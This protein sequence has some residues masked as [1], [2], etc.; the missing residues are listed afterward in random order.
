MDVSDMDRIYGS[1]AN[2]NGELDREWYE[3]NIVSVLLPYPMRR[4]GNESVVVRRVPFHRK[5]A[6]DLVAALRTAWYCARNLATQEV[7]FESC[8]P[9]EWD[10]LTMLK[11]RDDGLDLFGGSFCFRK[12]RRGA[13][14]SEHARGTAIDIDPDGNPFGSQSTRMPGYAIAAFHAWGFVWGGDFA[15]RRDPMHFQA[16]P[17]IAGDKREQRIILTQ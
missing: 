13:R 4:A 5:K 8:K 6:Y 3:Q 12:I 2:P 15:D 16:A 1:P 10:E 7:D 9:A 14:P 17:P 11:L